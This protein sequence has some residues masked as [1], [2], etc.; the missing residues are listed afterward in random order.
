MVAVRG[1]LLDLARELKVARGRYPDPMNP[2]RKTM[3]PLPLELAALALDAR[4][5]LELIA[6]EHVERA[7][8]LDGLT[9]EQV[10]ERLDIS[11]QSAHSR[12]R[13]RS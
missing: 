6:S 11:M 13:R 5:A 9:W 4:D 1:A 8:E 7:R 12:F 2:A 10:G 3:Q